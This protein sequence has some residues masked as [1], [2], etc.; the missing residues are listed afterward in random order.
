MEPYVAAKL[1][2]VEFLDD[3]IAASTKSVEYCTELEESSHWG[4]HIIGWYVYYD[5]GSN[6]YISGADKPEI[7]P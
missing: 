3:V 7:C 1:E 6:G 2:I 4:M 5:D